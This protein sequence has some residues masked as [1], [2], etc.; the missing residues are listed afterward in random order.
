MPFFY[1]S[2]L[3]WIHYTVKESTGFVFITLAFVNHCF[4]KLQTSFNLS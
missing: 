2:R 3:V 4:V 1:F